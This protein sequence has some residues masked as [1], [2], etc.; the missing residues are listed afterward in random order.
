MKDNKLFHI[1]DLIE[2]IRELDK[3]I[4]LHEKNNSGFM[5]DQYTHKK[6]KLSGFLFKELIIS[7]D[8]SPEVMYLI[9]LFLG[10]FYQKEIKN[11]KFSDGDAMKK[12]EELV[13]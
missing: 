10:K 11:T 7:N 12:I 2:E 1:I 3:M 9:S 8:S 5:L 6:V 4:D 13:S